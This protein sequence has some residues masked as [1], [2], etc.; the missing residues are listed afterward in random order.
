ML[1]LRKTPLSE[2]HEHL[3]G[4]MMD[5][6]NWYLPVKFKGNSI[7]N[8]HLWTRNHCGIFDIC[9]MTEFI[10][11][12]EDCIPYLKSIMTNSIDMNDFQAQYQHMC[13]PNGS[14][15]DDLYIYREN[16]TRFRIIGN[17]QTFETDG[18]DFNW[19]KDHIKDYQVTIRDF[20]LE[21]ARIAFQGLE[22]YS[23]LNNITDKDLS[24][25]KRFHWRYTNLITNNGI[26]PIFCSRTGYTGIDNGKI[27][28]NIIGSYEISCEKKYAQSVYQALLDTGAHPIGLGARD[29]L[30]LECAYPL[31][32]NELSKEITSI[33][34][35]LSWVVKKKENSN[36]IGEEILF[37]QKEQGTEIILVGLDLKEKG[38]L[39]SG[40]K[41]F[42]NDKEIGRITSGTFGPSVDKTIGLALIQTQYNNL[43]QELEV[44]I[45][46]KRKKV[47]IIKT[48]FW[49]ISN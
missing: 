22:A 16:A 1:N 46:S 6:E 38:I 45:R 43:G 39:R 14:V 34:A 7:K 47:S 41:L 27:N 28:E 49:S 40:Y 9:H 25:L 2:M 10:L 8:E 18:K 12:G 30:R 17:G 44:E 4:V 33:E 37:K 29:S 48:P 35:N 36:F 11:E 32:G 26:V 3:G 42:F 24:D 23:K 20:S 31:Y 21:R 13:Y 19:I 5:F 15:V